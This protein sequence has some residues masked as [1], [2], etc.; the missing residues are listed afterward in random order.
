MIS[1]RVP[2][3]GV[4]RSRGIAHGVAERQVQHLAMT[5]AGQTPEQRAREQF[6]DSHQSPVMP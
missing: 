5:A 6:G 2:A 3:V 1:V 4:E